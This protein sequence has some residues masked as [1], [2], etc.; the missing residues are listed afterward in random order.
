MLW[1]FHAERNC[2]LNCSQDTRGECY[3]LDAGTV[4][5]LQENSACTEIIISSGIKKV[6]VG[7]MDRILS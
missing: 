7:T 5:P 2:I 3:V 4:L 1:S 6:V